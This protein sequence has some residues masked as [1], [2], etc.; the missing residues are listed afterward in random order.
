MG[1]DGGNHWDSDGGGAGPR[2]GGQR[3][4]VGGPGVGRILGA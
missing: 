3:V 1:W 4:G 2:P